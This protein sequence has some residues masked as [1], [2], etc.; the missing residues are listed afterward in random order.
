MLK[1]DFFD[2]NHKNLPS[3]ETDRQLKNNK[4]TSNLATVVNPKNHK[5]EKNSVPQS[6]LGNIADR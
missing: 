3:L 2:E 4:S 5:D 6:S 1:C